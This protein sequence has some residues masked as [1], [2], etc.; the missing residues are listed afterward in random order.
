VLYSSQDH[1]GTGTCDLTHP[2]LAGAKNSIVGTPGRGI[3]SVL[4]L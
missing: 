4:F 3:Y 2:V 1:L